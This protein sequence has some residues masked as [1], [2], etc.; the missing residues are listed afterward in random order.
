[1]G[2]HNTIVLV[3]LVWLG[4]SIKYNGCNLFLRGG[5]NGFSDA[6][7]I[8]SIKKNLHISFVPSFGQVD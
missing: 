1:V 7:K 2:E 3:A 5:K 6:I 4:S 8:S